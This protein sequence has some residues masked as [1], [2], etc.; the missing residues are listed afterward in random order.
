MKHVLY[1]N[2]EEGKTQIRFL[3]SQTFHSHDP[4]T[5]C[6]LQISLETDSIITKTELHRPTQGYM[7]GQ[8]KTVSQFLSHILRTRWRH[9]KWTSISHE[10]SQHIPR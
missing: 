9:S 3:Y 7:K 6:G 10:T 5:V 4:A 8:M 2:K 1:R